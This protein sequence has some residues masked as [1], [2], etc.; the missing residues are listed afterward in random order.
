MEMNTTERRNRNKDKKCH[1]FLSLSYFG[2]HEI[3][4]VNDVVG[5]DMY[6][7]IN[8]YLFLDNVFKHKL[9]LFVCSSSCFNETTF[10]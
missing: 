9:F 5:R 6:G 10:H 1:K 4:T 7:W 8:V 2:M 3:N